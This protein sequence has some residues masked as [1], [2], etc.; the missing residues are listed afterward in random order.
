M[1]KHAFHYKNRNCQLKTHD[2]DLL[3]DDT[4]KTN[5][6]DLIHKTKEAMVDVTKQLDTGGGHEMKKVILS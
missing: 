6:R 1:S 4:V 5:V 2:M 3:P